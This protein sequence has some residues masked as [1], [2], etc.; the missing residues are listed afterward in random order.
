MLISLLLKKLFQDLCFLV[1]LFW[2]VHECAA[3]CSKLCLM[4]KSM[5]N[6]STGVTNGF[7]VYSKMPDSLC[8]L[9]SASFTA[10]LKKSYHYSWNTKALHDSLFFEAHG[11]PSCAWFIPFVKHF[12]KAP[13]SYRLSHSWPACKS[14]AFD[15]HVC[16]HILNDQTP[17][18][19]S[20]RDSAFLSVCVGISYTSDSFCFSESEHFVTVFGKV[21]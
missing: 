12:C 3:F 4:G 16:R 21:S 9:F 14:L 8:L 19:F 18:C 5:Q 2:K 15:T 1:R 6:H 13:W 7:C 10:G 20:D 11:S 17:K